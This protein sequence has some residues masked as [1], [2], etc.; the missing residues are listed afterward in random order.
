MQQQDSVENQEPTSLMADQIQS[1]NLNSEHKEAAKKSCE[2]LNTL[3]TEF[4]TLLNEPH[5]YINQIVDDINKR[6]HLKHDDIKLKLN[7]QIEF[8]TAQLDAYANECKEKA[9]EPNSNLKNMNEEAKRELAKWLNEL[10][11]GDEN[12]FNN[13]RSEINK[14]IFN[15][16]VNLTNYKNFLFDGPLKYSEIELLEKINV[17]SLFRYKNFISI[18]S[19]RL[20]C[21]FNSRSIIKLD[22]IILGENM[23][24]ELFD[25]CKFRTGIKFN[26]LY[27]ASRD[28]FRSIDFHSRC[29]NK[30]KTLTICRD[31]KGFIVGG[32]TEAMWASPQFPT[33]VRDPEAF[34]FSLNKKFQPIKIN[35]ANKYENYAIFNSP[36]HG[37][38]FGKP[39]FGLQYFS[40]DDELNLKNY[41]GVKYKFVRF[42]YNNGSFE[43]KPSFFSSR[44]SHVSEL[45]VFQL[46]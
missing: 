12:N 5:T 45:E 29:D 4:S 19:L 20:L 46:K 22:S 26:L 30:P 2:E 7:Q 8:I 34:I 39:N 41:S 44:K 16:K 9:K 10:N 36:F 31:N 38:I 18:L 3:I 37:P 1:L 42:I 15:L 40:V 23:K 43:V 28:G 11:C 27:R 32:Y 33:C 35:I 14:K 25:L 6:I 17:D 24:K 21:F 13:I